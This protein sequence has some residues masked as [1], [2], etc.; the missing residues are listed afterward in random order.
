MNLEEPLHLHKEINELPFSIVR[1]KQI[2]H[3]GF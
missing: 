3:I 1:E 2:L